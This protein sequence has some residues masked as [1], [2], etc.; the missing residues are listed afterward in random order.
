M[1]YANDTKILVNQDGYI[2]SMSANTSLS[3]TPLTKSIAHKLLDQLKEGSMT[4]SH[5]INQA[6]IKTGDLNFT[7]LYSIS[8]DNHHITP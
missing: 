2:D 3:D 7:N 6:L 8:L 5:L 1:N 4:H